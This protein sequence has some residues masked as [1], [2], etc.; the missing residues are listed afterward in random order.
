MGSLFLRLIPKKNFVP[1]YSNLSIQET[2][3]I[4]AELDSRGVAYE[5][6][7]GGTTINVP[8]NQVDTL[9]VELAGKGLPNNGNIDYSIFSENSSFGIT[10]NEF[11]MMKLDA[12]QSEL[13]NLI[14]ALKGFKMPKL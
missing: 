8:E 7:D 1:L 12:M 14:T 11:N 5:L 3:Q 6:K 4:K 2:S 9:L 10:D 13:A